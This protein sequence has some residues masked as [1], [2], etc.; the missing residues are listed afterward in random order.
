MKAKNVFSL[1]NNKYPAFFSCEWDDTGIEVGNINQDVNKI[2]ITLDVNMRIIEEA[3]KKKCEL[4]VAHHPL[5]FDSIS[6][7]NN[8][9]QSGAEIIKAIKNN[10]CIFSV[11]TNLDIM[12]GGLNDYLA[13]LFNLEEISPIR[14]LNSKNYFK[15]VV[16]IPESHYEEVKKAIFA[17]GAGKSENYS[18]SAFSVKG[19][20]SFKPLSGSN[21]Y[22]GS[23]EKITETDEYRFETIV[24]ENKLKRVVASMKRVHPYEEVAYDVYNLQNVKKKYG[25]GRIGNLQNSIKLKDFV[26]NIKKTLDKHQLK[27]TGNVD[28]KIQK[29]AICNGSGSDLI[30]DVYNLKADVFITGDI[31][32]HDA[33]LAENLNLILIDAG[34]YE[35]EIVVKDFL[36]HDLKN[37]LKEKDMNLKIIRSELETKPWQLC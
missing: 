36:Y 34:H 35:T 12:P 20:G 25:L 18:C 22:Q 11:H 13:N 15:L 5:I 17:E 24:P 16:F 32:Y 27:I 14:I 31:K 8:Y 29:V 23:I 2:L 4:I 37:L 21:P 26:K 3:I 1:L 6:T 7:V 19:R 9:N 28:K 10:I 33:Q 30:Q